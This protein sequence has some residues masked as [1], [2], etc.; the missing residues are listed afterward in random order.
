MLGQILDS[1]SHPAWN[2]ASTSLMVAATAMLVAATCALDAGLTAFLGAGTVGCASLLCAR[3]TRGPA[4]RHWTHATAPAQTQCGTLGDSFA[5][6]FALMRSP[7]VGVLDGHGFVQAALGETAGQND[8]RPASAS[9]L[10]GADQRPGLR[11]WN[12]PEAKSP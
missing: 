2:G 4:G 6:T 5:V 9:Y 8:R 3:V 10:Y 11:P 12:R 7:F 1:L